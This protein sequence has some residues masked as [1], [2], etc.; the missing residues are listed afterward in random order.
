ML[1]SRKFEVKFIVEGFGFFVNCFYMKV[2]VEC[3]IWNEIW[4]ICN[5][6][7]CYIWEC[8]DFVGVWCFISCLYPKYRRLGLLC[9]DFYIFFFVFDVICIK[10][11]K[12]KIF[13]DGSIV[14]SSPDLFM[15]MKNKSYA[16]LSIIKKN[17]YLI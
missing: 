1:F 5:F 7:E 17:F 4:G 14:E 8:L 6:A 13:L 9:S 10:F 2:V 16:R 15:S 11:K 3:M 12:K